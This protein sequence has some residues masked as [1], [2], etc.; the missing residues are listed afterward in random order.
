MSK[1]KIAA[2]VGGAV[3]LIIILC[4]AASC[5]PT[6]HKAADSSSTPT[7]SVSAS[8]SATTPQV[9]KISPTAATVKGF[10]AGIWQVG[11]EIPAGSYVTTGVGIN[12]YWARLTSDSGDFD[13]IITNGNVK[14]D[15]RG[16]VGVKASDKFVEFRGECVWTKV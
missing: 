9:V 8:L 2:I 15:Q 1:G 13:S 11:K 5:L 7:P 4:C 16:R 6:L 10:G 14:R 3:A 12:C